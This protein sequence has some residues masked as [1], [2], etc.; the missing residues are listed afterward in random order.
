[1]SA[2]VTAVKLTPSCVECQSNTV[3]RVLKRQDI[4]LELQEAVLGDQDD[5]LV[6]GRE[7][8]RSLSE[9]YNHA[10]E[11]LAIDDPLADAKR[12]HDEA[13]LE[14]LPAARELIAAQPDALQAAIRVSAVGNTLDFSISDSF[15]V[16]GLLRDAMELE[17]A[18]NDIDRLRDRLRTAKDLVLFTDNA[19]E[20]V[21]DRLLLDAVQR[22]RAEQGLTPLELTVVVKG[23]PTLNDALREDAEL[24]GMNEIATI[25]DTGYPAMG[26][27]RG[28]V[29]PQTLEVIENADVVIAKG[30]ANFETTFEDDVIPLHTFYLLKAK[31]LP[32]ASLVGAPVGTLV[33]ADGAVHSPAGKATVAG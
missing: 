9:F 17:F 1:M 14:M 13:V 22:W 8:G 7:L 5:Y 2:E 29:A 30:M 25:A 32:V 6:P 11:R 10:R 16:P 18:I 12:Q 24:A 26:I 15:D 4:P 3:M 23:G 31:C 28:L 19:G 21:F 27:I 20:V 33:L